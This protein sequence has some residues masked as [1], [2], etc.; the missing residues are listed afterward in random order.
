MSALTLCE[1]HL[2]FAGRQQRWQHTSASLNC[3]M[4]FSVFLPPQAAKGKVPL[5]WCLAGLTCTDEN[6]SVKSGAQRLAAELGIALVMPDTSP[7]G[8]D[9]PNDASYDLG[10]G[11][12][13]YLNATQAPWDRHFKMYDYLTVELP[14]LLAE[15][16]PVTERQAIMGHS[17]GGHGALV[18]ALRQAGRY[19]SVSAFAPIVNPCA[20]PWGQKAFS[21]YLGDD[22]AAAEGYDATLL[23]AKASHRLP[24]LVDQGDSDNFYPQQLQPEALQAVAQQQGFEFTLRWQKGYDHSYFFIASVV[25][26]HLRFHGRYLLP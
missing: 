19:T 14:T 10:Q 4:K 1:E 7:R 17:M 8:E 11:A 13:F 6:F 24:V 23:M 22:R 25:E 5:L 21:A 15:H 18:L 20:V 12:G 9:V 2:M 3:E 16:F 26:D